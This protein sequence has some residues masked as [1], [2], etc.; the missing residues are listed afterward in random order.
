MLTNVNI[1]IEQPVR[2]ANQNSPRW[3]STVT[4]DAMRE[5]GTMVTQTR[6]NVTLSDLLSLLPD[7][8]AAT[9]VQRWMMELA[10]ELVDRGL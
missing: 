7:N 1:A 10:Q 6:N 4:V 2:G 9:F 8:E 5:D 3:T